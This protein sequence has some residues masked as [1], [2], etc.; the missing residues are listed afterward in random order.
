MHDRHAADV[1]ITMTPVPWHGGFDDDAMATDCA[2]G[3]T[4]IVHAS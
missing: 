2:L 4:M 1:V 3:Q